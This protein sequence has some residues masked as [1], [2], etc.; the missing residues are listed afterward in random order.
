MVVK[1][2]EDLIEEFVFVTVLNIQ[3]LELLVIFCP[4]SW[5]NLPYLG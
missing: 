5:L 2:D 1:I 4:Y 3:L